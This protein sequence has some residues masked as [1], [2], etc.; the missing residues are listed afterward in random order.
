MP[1]PNTNP[2][3]RLAA[4]QSY[5]REK[6]QA[7]RTGKDISRYDR[8][9]YVTLAM[10]Q[11]GFVY[12][13]ERC[14]KAMADFFPEAE[15]IVCTGTSGLLIAP[16]VAFLTGLPL[17][18]LRK[19]GD[20][21]HSQ[22]KLEGRVEIGRYVFLDD[23]VDSGGT[24]ARVERTL[25]DEHAGEDTLLGVIGYRCHGGSR[26]LNLVGRETPGYK[27]K[28]V[29]LYNPEFLQFNTDMRQMVLEGIP[30][31]YGTRPH[32]STIYI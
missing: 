13:V 23:T 20:A 28:V 9:N 5:H 27:S 7:H 22:A 18:F 19:P 30:P 31:D 11:R 26:W 29:P 8:D 21:C 24:L 6:L 3:D 10:P 25:Y 16:T 32:S 2:L 4:A 15:T 14:V 1:I 17:S 12:Y